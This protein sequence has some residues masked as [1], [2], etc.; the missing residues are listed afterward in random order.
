MPGR[1]RPIHPQT[2]GPPDLA[3]RP[4]FFPSFFLV[5]HR[6]RRPAA[7]ETMLLCIV[8]GTEVGFSLVH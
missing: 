8:V 5:A 7:D 6:R 1:R 2:R 4:Q 3:A